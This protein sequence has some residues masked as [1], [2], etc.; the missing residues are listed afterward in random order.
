MKNYL[1]IIVIAIIVTGLFIYVN[2]YH[3]DNTAPIYIK[4]TKA[5][6]P[7]EIVALTEGQTCE[8]MYDSI[9][10]DLDNANYCDQDSDCDAILLGGRYMEFGCY[11]YINKNIDQ[12]SILQNMY[13]YDEKCDEM[14]NDCDLA[15]EAQ[16]VSGE[17]VEVEQ[18]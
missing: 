2:L 16:C 8:E 6:T 1:I 10:N 11:H 15:L 12:S 13:I 3:E 18:G 5:D 7:V 17:C 4:N 14:I 9:E